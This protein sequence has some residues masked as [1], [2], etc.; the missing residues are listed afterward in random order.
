MIN[1]GRADRW[2]PTGD[3]HLIPSYDEMEDYPSCRCA[4]D[5]EKRVVPIYGR[6][7]NVV[8]HFQNGFWANFN[9]SKEAKYSLKSSEFYKYPSTTLKNCDLC[10]RLSTPKKIVYRSYIYGWNQK[11]KN[12]YLTKSKDYLC[13]GC[14]NKVRALVKK[15]NICDE[16]RR[17]I[18]KIKLEIAKWLKSQQQES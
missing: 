15:Q 1:Y 18:S 4:I 6:P 2:I 10:G 11:D 5:L 9:K 12:D 17:L 13:M 16:N 8:K 3:G 14:W 7:Y